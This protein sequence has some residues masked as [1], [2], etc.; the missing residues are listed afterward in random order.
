MSK[1]ITVADVTGD[2]KA[3]IIGADTAGMLWIYPQSAAGFTSRT[4]LGGGWNG[5]T[6]I[7]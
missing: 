6:W 4:S 1:I 7:G 2:G 3:D 5:L